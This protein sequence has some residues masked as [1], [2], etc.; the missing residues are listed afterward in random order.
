MGAI[1]ERYSDQIVITSDNPRSESPLSIIGEIGVGLA[2]P[3]KS[4]VEPDRKAAIQWAIRHAQPNDVVMVAG[5]GHETYQIVAGE[6]L[7]FDDREECRA[8]I[9]E[10]YEGLN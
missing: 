3:E 8:A 1:A 4:K 5:K 2:A 6:T 7:H 10:R 9:K